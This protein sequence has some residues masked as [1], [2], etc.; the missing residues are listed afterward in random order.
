[1]K[2]EYYLNVSI[3]KAG[4]NAGKGAT[5]GSLNIPKDVLKDMGIT[6]EDKE[7]ILSY[8]PESKEITIKKAPKTTIL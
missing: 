3:R 7:I 6:K 8:D 5:R 2:E 1:M 4:G